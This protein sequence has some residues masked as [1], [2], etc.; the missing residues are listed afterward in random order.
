MY[1]NYSMKNYETKLLLQ[2]LLLQWVILGYMIITGICHLSVHTFKA[3]IS[4][5]VHLCTVMM[6]NVDVKH[7]QSSKTSGEHM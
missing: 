6:S 1:D 4:F 7:C 5:S 2:I 3:D